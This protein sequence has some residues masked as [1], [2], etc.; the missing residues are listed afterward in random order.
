MLIYLLVGVLM[1]FCIFLQNYMMSIK[2]VKH[3]LKCVDCAVD[4]LVQILTIIWLWPFIL[5]FRILKQTTN[6]NK[7]GN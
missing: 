7:R 6:T 2:T 3:S 1:V 4:Y 5:I